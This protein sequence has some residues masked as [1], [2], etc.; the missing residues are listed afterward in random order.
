MFHLLIEHNSILII[1][2]LFISFI[3][4]QLYKILW[5]SAAWIIL[6]FNWISLRNLLTTAWIPSSSC[7]W[8]S[9]KRSHECSYTHTQSHTTKK[10]T[11]MTLRKQTQF[12]SK[13][14]AILNLHLRTAGQ[15]KRHKLQF[16]RAEWELEQKQ[17]EH[18][19]YRAPCAI[20]RHQ[21]PVVRATQQTANWTV[22][23]PL[24]AV[25]AGA[26]TKTKHN[27]R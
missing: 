19:E 10:R 25:A 18:T 5:V 6:L 1:S 16:E 11:K 23:L 20:S 4:Y 15:S 27:M 2:K 3:N 9:H 14:E 21:L 17:T 12:A 13:F 22:C 26:N 24:P 7:C 8:L